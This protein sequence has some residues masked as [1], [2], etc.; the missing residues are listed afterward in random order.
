MR[1][2]FRIGEKKLCSVTGNLLET[3]LS[4]SRYNNDYNKYLINIKASVTNLIIC[5]ITTHV[6]TFQHKN[7]ALWRAHDNS[8]AYYSSIRYV[9]YWYVTNEQVSA[10]I[11]FVDNELNVLDA[12]S[13]LVNGTLGVT[14][15]RGG[16]CEISFERFG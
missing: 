12:Q 5:K 16:A 14:I 9:Q 4:N 3:T 8:A 2:I 1:R 6:D 10:L 13:K 15:W 7:G 11:T